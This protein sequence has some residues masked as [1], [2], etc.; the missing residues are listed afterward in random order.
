VFFWDFGLAASDMRRS[1]RDR[2]IAILGRNRVGL[3]LAQAL[4]EAGFT[5]L[6]L[7]DAPVFR[8]LA[9]PPAHDVLSEAAWQAREV[10][11]QT[12]IM[13]SEFGGKALLRPWNAWALE[14]GVDFFPVILQ[15]LF[16]AIGPYVVP[17]ETPCYECL[18]GR[19][20]SNID[21]P[22]T[23]RRFEAH[24]FEGQL[25]AGHHPLMPR[26]VADMAA[27][28]LVKVL[29]GIGRGPI[30]RLVTMNPLDSETTVSRVMRLPYCPACSTAARAARPALGDIPA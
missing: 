7:V 14:N 27:F 12:L 26:M 1:F 9:L 29:S 30:G 5:R 13:A 2:E 25:A 23:L 3:A 22:A 4:D 28:E 16:G 18:R 10:P 17:G 6:S 20:N 21:D 15:T 11:P 8:N 19:E 24:A